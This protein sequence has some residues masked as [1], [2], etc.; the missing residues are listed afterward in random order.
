MVGSNV[1]LHVVSSAIDKSNYGKKDPKWRQSIQ[2]MVVLSVYK[3]FSLS[4][5]VDFSN[6]LLAL[7]QTLLI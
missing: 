6:N 5:G 1:L 3:P 2:D 4:S 7:L